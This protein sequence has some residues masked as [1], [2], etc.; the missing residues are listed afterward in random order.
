MVWG[1]GLYIGLRMGSSSGIKVQRML[2][3]KDYGGQV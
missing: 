2:K 1:L 3:S